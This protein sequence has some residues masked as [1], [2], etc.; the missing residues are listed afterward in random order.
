VTP[1]G[2]GPTEDNM[3]VRLLSN[4][5]STA[6][7][8]GLV[9]VFHPA[10][11]AF[12]VTEGMLLG[13]GIVLTVLAIVLD[14]KEY[15]GKR[16]K[17]LRTK[18]QIREYMFR[19]IE[20]GGK[21]CIFSNDLSWVDDDEMVSMLKS[22]AGKDEL[23]ICVPSMVP[24]AE[25]LKAA[26]ATI[27]TYAPLKVTPLSRFTIINCGRMDSQVAVGRRLDGQH[28]VEEFGAGDHPVFAVASDLVEIITKYSQTRRSS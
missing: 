22:K 1:I 27:L 12:S 19:W 5:G 17:V 26:G 13:A 3:I 4:L 8:I 25:T 28:V 11:Q 2:F 14:L 10:G 18:Q 24:I 23:K 15:Y 21:V 6:S 7:L 16:P 9:F 20:N